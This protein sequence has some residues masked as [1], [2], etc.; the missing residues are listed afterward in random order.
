VRRYDMVN[1]LRADKDRLDGWLKKPQIYDSNAR[2]LLGTA[3]GGEGGG[4]SSSSSAGGG[5][6][7]RV[8]G[9]ETEETRQLDNEG[10]LQ[11]QKQNL[12]MQDS[13][14][15]QLMSTLARQKAIASE[16][17]N[18][19]GTRGVRSRTDFYFSQTPK[20]KCWT[21]STTMSSRPRARSSAR[22]RRC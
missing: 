7:R 13:A 1:K 6:G 14:L 17:G 15:D 20:T 10:L 18:E 4:S 16:I 9:Q 22:T 5:R 19:L 3:G 21:S 2:E 12:S 8:F 11:M